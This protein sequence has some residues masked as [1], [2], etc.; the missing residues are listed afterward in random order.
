MDD[1][2]SGLAFMAVACA[3]DKVAHAE[4]EELTFT[5]EGVALMLPVIGG[6]LLSTKAL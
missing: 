1:V 2:D 5:V 3:A 6:S 4:F